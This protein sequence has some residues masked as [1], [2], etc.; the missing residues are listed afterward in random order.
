MGI[1]RKHNHHCQFINIH[2]GIYGKI[3]DLFSLPIGTVNSKSG[4]KEKKDRKFRN[5]KKKNQK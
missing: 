4:A 5:E 3:S 2:Y 1:L